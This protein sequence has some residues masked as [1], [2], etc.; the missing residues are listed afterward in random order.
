[1]KMF[2]CSTMLKFWM[3]IVT[4]KCRRTIDESLRK[5]SMLLSYKEFAFFVL[6]P[7]LVFR[8]FEFITIYQVGW[9]STSRKP[10]YVEGRF[11]TMIIVDTNILMRGTA[12]YIIYM[13]HGM[14]PS[15]YLYFV[16]LFLTAMSFP[17]YFFGQPATM[18]LV[19]R[20]AH[21]IISTVC[22][23]SF[24]YLDLF[25]G[26]LSIPYVIFAMARTKDSYNSYKLEAERQK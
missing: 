16:S 20:L 17:I 22:F 23:I 4:V 1:M 19:I 10:D 9:Y 15:L 13:G 24:S 26:L 18:D 12:A 14:D 11:V 7:V 3:L 6:M 8:I 5:L 21:L 25:A 2:D